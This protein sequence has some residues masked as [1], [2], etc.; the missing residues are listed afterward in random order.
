M[1]SELLCYNRGCGKTYRPSDNDQDCKSTSIK[2]KSRTTPPRVLF[3]AAPPCVFHPGAPFFHDAY[4]GW[5]CCNRKA[6]DFTEF[7]NFPG[8]TEGKHSHVK[9]VE[10]EKITG[11]L[12]FDSDAKQT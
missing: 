4:K 10:P 2:Q 1:D 5:T 8:C 3:L 7:L 12:R 6:T 11:N 9:P